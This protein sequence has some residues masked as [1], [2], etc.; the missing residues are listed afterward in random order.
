MSQQFGETIQEWRRARRLS[1]SAL[2]ARAGIAK[3]TLSGWERGLHQPRL[4]ELEA[5]LTA[6]EAPAQYRREALALI[7]AP[8]A[9]RSLA[10]ELS[11]PV[12]IGLEATALPVPGHLLRALRQRRGLTLEAVAREMGVNRSA[13]SRWERSL[14]TPPTARLEQLLRLLG[15]RFEERAALM[16]SRRLLLSVDVE[17]GPSLETLGQRF[18]TLEL[19]VLQGD[20][21]LL[22][23]E[24]HAWQAE[25]WPLIGRSASA[26]ALLAEGW[27][28]YAE[29]ITW[30]GRMREA[31]V[32][33]KRAID[34]IQAEG[35]LT[36]AL[37]SPMTVAMHVYGRVTGQGK[38]REAKAA[39]VEWLQAWLPDATGSDWEV[40]VYRDMAEHAWWAG[41]PEAAD[42]FSKHALSLEEWKG[43]EIVRAGSHETRSDILVR[44]GNA[45]K[46]I[47]LLDPPANR[48]PVGRIRENLRWVSLLQALGDP[49]AADW[50][51]EAYTLIDQHDYPQFRA[52]ADVLARQF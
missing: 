33:A 4:P 39:A 9:R 44:S 20:R 34:L 49:A 41:R 27:A 31:G 48:F 25:L 7:E 13:V 38:G 32:Y 1:L 28:F 15:A 12:S 42:A 40:F 22:D 8:R 2:A 11:T 50:L 16:D 5:V 26:R 17:R 45:E 6:L 36:A 24:F 43:R 30:S 10:S 14:S 18:R 23:L 46:A 37:M 21:A 3:G 35:R 52:Q 47:A 19:G 51:T 29:W